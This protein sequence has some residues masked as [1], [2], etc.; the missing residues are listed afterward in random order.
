MCAAL[1][2]PC[3]K[4]Y[5]RASGSQ[6]QEVTKVEPSW[7]T[8]DNGFHKLDCLFQSKQITRGAIE[9]HCRESRA[10]AG[11]VKRWK[12]LCVFGSDWSQAAVLPDVGWRDG[13]RCSGNIGLRDVSHCTM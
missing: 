12:R 6:R 5:R 3:A 11:P 2:E 7:E 9:P 4:R 1:A 13:W 8:A 10:Q